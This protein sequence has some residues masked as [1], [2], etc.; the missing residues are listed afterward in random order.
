MGDRI[1]LQTLLEGV[2]G[3]DFV[4]FQPPESFRMSYPCIVYHRSHIRT[5]YADNNPYSLKKEYM[6]TVIDADPDSNIPDKIAML[7]TALHDRR[8]TVD[9]LNHD[10]F[11]M[12]F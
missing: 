11:T 4:Y 8:H 2:L 6:I 7:F 5:D 1:D 12:F 9:N 3:S 10:V